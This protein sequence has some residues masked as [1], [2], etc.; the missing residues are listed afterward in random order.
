MATCS[1]IGSLLSHV[2]TV[3]T[4]VCV[5]V[6]MCVF[7]YFRLVLFSIHWWQQRKIRND[8]C[9]P[10]RVQENYHHME[11]CKP[12][13]AKAKPVVAKKPCD[14]V[15]RDWSLYAYWCWSAVG[16]REALMGPRTCLSKHFE[17]ISVTATGLP[18][19]WCWTAWDDGGIFRAGWNGKHVLR[20]DWRCW[21]KSL[22][23]AVHNLWGPCLES[24]QTLVRFYVHVVRIFLKLVKKVVELLSSWCT[25]SQ[26]WVPAAPVISYLLDVTPHTHTL[27]FP[28]MLPL[29]FQ[30]SFW[31][32][33]SPC[34]TPLCSPPCRL[35]HI[36]SG[37]Y[38]PHFSPMASSLEIHKC[39]CWWWPQHIF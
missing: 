21:W 22:Q 10:V 35:H 34:L 16:E 1:T 24:H 8:K 12:Y 19:S 6:R 33:V 2:H 14:G 39:T 7:I 37:E 13:R 30:Y 31:G 20:R 5:C 15:E 36:L 9:V 23:T 17:I 27:S 32:H 3:H 29:L 18:G 4:Y 28:C 11:V 25:V 38:V 26:Q